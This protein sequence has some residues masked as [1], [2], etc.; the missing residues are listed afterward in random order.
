MTSIASVPAGREVGASPRAASP[1]PWLVLCGLVVLSFVG[2]VFLGSTVVSP[3]ELWTALRS[4]SGG[5][6]VH[7]FWELRVPRALLGLLVGAS[8]G[9]S[10][11]CLQGLLH[12]PLVEPGIGGVS[13]GAAL[14][15]VVAL[16]TGLS[17]VAGLGLP[18]AGMMGALAA[19]WTVELI[20]GR[21]A[22]TQGVLLGGLVL[23]TACNALVALVLNLS[24][25]PMASLEI[26]F[27][28]MG[29][30]TDRSMD[31]VRWVLG[32]ML[33]G[34][35][36]MLSCGRALRAWSLGADAAS[37]LGIHARWLRLRVMLGSAL[38]VGAAVSVSGS[39]GFVGLFV[40]HLIRPWVRADPARL[41]AASALGGA[42]VLCWADVAVRL[43]ARLLQ[44]SEVK[45]G[46]MTALLGT[47]PLAILAL[48]SRKGGLR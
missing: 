22:S 12:N 38:A 31:H 16:Y 14:G 17:P 45:L 35:A 47:V 18:V 4:D 44:G 37:S 1:W 29:S 46:V 48:K 9:L 21:T 6:L 39:I 32:P 7:I 43:S 26:M 41:L 8:L 5:V 13:A 19:V 27:W 30:L 25:N 33:V 20:G 10:G 34:M 23:T 15:A 40:P 24:R 3:V 11:A 36:L 2:S 42:L 28:L